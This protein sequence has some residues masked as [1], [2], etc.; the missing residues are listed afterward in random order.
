MRSE[1]YVRYR[2]DVEQIQPDEAH[3][4]DAIVESMA[5]GNQL[6]FDKHR[7]GLRDAHAKSHG[8]LKGELRVD[9]NLPEH[10]RQGLFA[11]PCTYPIA[12]RFSTAPG[13]LRTDQ[14]ATPRGMAIKVIGVDGE[15]A[16]NDGHTTQDFLLVNSPIIPFGDV[17]AYLQV[18]KHV[19]DGSSRSDASLERASLAARAVAKVFDIAHVEPPRAL[20]GITESNSHILGQTFHSMAALRFGDYIAKISAAPLSAE[21]KALV[22]EDIPSDA[23]PS[24]LRDLVVEFFGKNAATYEL[25][26]Q[27]CTNLERMPVEDGSVLW[28]EDESPQQR[29]GTITLFAQEAYSNARRIYGDD[30]LSFS[31]WHALAAHRPLGSIQRVRMQAYERSS[32]FRHEMNAVAGHEPSDLADIPD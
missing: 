1:A 13:D 30:V 20:Q 32:K 28:P 27:L 14:V 16:L 3:I 29:I 12:V 19:E 21:V 23:G 8:I 5:R 2:D 11:K 6:V 10:L 15:R 18:Q 24:V 4:I 7:H 26:A 25:R 22:D 31:P 9:E 17:K